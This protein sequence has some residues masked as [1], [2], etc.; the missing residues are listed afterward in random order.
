[1]KRKLTELKAK[2]G[3]TFE[4]KQ[5]PFQAPRRKAHRNVKAMIHQGV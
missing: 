4:L 5:K 1:M 2:G 3:K